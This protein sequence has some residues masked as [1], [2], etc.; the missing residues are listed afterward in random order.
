MKASRRLVLQLK[1]CHVADFARSMAVAVT[2][3][4]TITCL[5]PFH[6]CSLMGELGQLVTCHSWLSF[7][8][9]KL[10]KPCPLPTSNIRALPSSLLPLD[11]SPQTPDSSKERQPF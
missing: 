5:P 8:L 9:S 4:H 6:L 10:A 1:G 3:H 11:S 2:E 7:G